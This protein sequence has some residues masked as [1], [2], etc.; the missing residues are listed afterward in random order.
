MII[1][2]SLSPQ[3]PLGATVTIKHRGYQIKPGSDTDYKAPRLQSLQKIWCDDRQYTER[4]VTIPTSSDCICF[5]L[6]SWR[7]IRNVVTLNAEN[8]RTPKEVSCLL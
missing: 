6:H 3:F 5:Q 4:T 1:S 8:G 7:T 2:S